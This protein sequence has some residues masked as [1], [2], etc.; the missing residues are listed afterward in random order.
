[1]ERI[2]CEIARRSDVVGIYPDGASLIPSLRRLQSKEAAPIA[3]MYS[4]CCGVGRCW[5]PRI[6]RTDHGDDIHEGVLA[7]DRCLI[8]WSRLETTLNHCF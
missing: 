1:L 7:L 8:W 2:D 3:D 6:V 4:D 5:T